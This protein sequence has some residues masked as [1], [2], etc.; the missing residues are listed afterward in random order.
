MAYKPSLDQILYTT[1][2]EDVDRRFM[3]QMAEQDER[4]VPTDANLPRVTLVVGPSPFSMPRGWE[5]FLTSP[6][7]GVSYIG[8]VLHNAGYAVRIVDV[9]YD[10]TPLQ[11][12]V[13][14]CQHD[15]DVIGLA[16]FE[17]NYPFLESFI[18]EVKAAR[19]DVPIILGG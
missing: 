18:A 9:R 14:A 2:A 8:T 17:D 3:A 5:F 12:A 16:T 15:T 13:A 10:P 11:T 6:Y 7:E 1:A 4:P 19:P